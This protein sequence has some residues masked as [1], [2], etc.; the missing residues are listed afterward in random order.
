MNVHF[1][2]FINE[3]QD[4]L[5]REWCYSKWINLPTSLRIIKCVRKWVHMPKFTGTC[6]CAGTCR[7]KNRTSGVFLHHSLP[8]LLEKSPPLTQKLTDIAQQVG[9]CVSR[10]LI[11]LPLLAFIWMLKSQNQ[12]FVLAKQA[13][14]FTEPSS[15]SYWLFP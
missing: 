5:S 7:C 4:P 6:V 14:L 2:I 15:N 9:Q 13:L 8:Y 3:S 10:M 1:T 12:V 11:F